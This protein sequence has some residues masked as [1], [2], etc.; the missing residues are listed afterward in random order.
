MIL[1]AVCNWYVENEEGGA[2]APPRTPAAPPAL[3]SRAEKDSKSNK[4]TLWCEVQGESN[5]C[6]PPWQYQ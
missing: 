6:L 4:H 2:A 5:I 3:P 1:S